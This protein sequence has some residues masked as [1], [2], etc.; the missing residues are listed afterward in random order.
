MAAA[1]HRGA[2]RP[3]RVRGGAHRAPRRKPAVETEQGLDSR[4]WLAL[5]V[6]LVAGFMD[7]LDAT[8]VNVA[9]P[10]IQSDLGAE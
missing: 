3:V 4:R 10:S 2:H 1:T 8:I 9:V 6:V 5:V 7:L